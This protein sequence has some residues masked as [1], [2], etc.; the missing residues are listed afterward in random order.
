MIGG[1]HGGITNIY[2]TK[3][4]T[5]FG[6]LCGTL[7]HIG[8]LIIVAGLYDC[9]SCGIWYNTLMFHIRIGRRGVRY[10]KS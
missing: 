10:A 8:V 2:A 3:Y 6:M 9:T 5:I 7:S 1:W 4:G